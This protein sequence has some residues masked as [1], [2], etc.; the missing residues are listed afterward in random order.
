MLDTMRVLLIVARAVNSVG[1]I[2]LLFI[3]LF[4]QHA[5]VIVFDSGLTKASDERVRPG[6]MTFSVYGTSHY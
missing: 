4:T 6:T 3:T 1:R 2:T 5:G